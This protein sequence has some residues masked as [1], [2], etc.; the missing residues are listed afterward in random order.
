MLK[1]DTNGY[2][3]HL[4]MNYSSRNPYYI[5]NLCEVVKGLLSSVAIICLMIGL[6]VGVSVLL[7]T[8]VVILAASRFSWELAVDEQ[9]FIFSLVS[10]G[11]AIVLCFCGWVDSKIAEARR[12]R[13]NKLY[14]QGLRP[15]DQP[16]LFAVWYDGVKNK[17]CPRVEFVDKSEDV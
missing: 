4:L 13:I 14:E 3:Y 8:W 5:N 17:Y 11:F 6:A 15:E 1:L 7:F 9:A 2:I 10:L 16:S 12:K